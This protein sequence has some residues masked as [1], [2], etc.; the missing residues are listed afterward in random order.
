MIANNSSRSGGGFFIT[1]NAS[2]Q[3]G[4]LDLLLCGKL[5]LFQR[6]CYLPVL[7]KGKHLH[8]PFVTH[9]LVKEIQI[10]LDQNT[11][12][13]I[14]GELISAK[15]IKISVVPNKFLFRF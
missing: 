8:L 7:Q 11:D 9:R 13:Q 2:F 14:D 5:S 6:L 15:E 10:S 4:H 3:D 1:P 12:I